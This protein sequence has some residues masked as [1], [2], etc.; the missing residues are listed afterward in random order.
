MVF[1]LHNKHFNRNIILFFIFLQSLSYE[2]ENLE[3]LKIIC[4]GNSLL[5]FL[6]FAGFLFTVFIYLTKNHLKR[7]IS[8]F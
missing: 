7:T 1:H 5:T 6:I 4:F 8:W 2:Q 3:I